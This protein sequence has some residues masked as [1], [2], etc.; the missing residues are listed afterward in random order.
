MHAHD[1]DIDE[2]EEGDDGDGSMFRGS[3]RTPNLLSAKRSGKAKSPAKS[4]P[5]N[6]PPAE[7][8]IVRQN[9]YAAGSVRNEG[10]SSQLLDGG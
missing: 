8:D 7:V 5:M 4:G 1:E 9:R 2:D 10:L 6:W 3:G